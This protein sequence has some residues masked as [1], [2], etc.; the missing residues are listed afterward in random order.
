VFFVEIT[1]FYCFASTILYLLLLFLNITASKMVR[2]T[3]A[4]TIAD[5]KPSQRLSSKQLAPIKD[6]DKHDDWVELYSKMRASGWTWK[7]GKGVVN[8]VYFNPGVNT[9]DDKQIDED[10]F[11]SEDNL[12]IYIRDHYGWTG[13]KEPVVKEMLTHKVKED[14]DSSKKSLVKDTVTTKKKRGIDSPKKSVYKDKV[15]HRLKVEEDSLAQFNS[16][17]ENQANTLS[18]G[19]FNKKKETMNPF[20]PTNLLLPV[21]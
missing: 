6:Y 5:I 7:T 15:T 1:F 3:R 11:Y 4:N 9:T 8:Y 14:E 10:Y 2:T 16:S 13:P 17:L 20:H 21:Y 18:I 12:Q 19:N